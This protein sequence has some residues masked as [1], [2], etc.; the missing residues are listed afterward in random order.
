MRPLAGIILCDEVSRGA[1]DG[2]RGNEQFDLQF[3]VVSFRIVSLRATGRSR[4]GA[5]TCGAREG[6]FCFHGGTLREAT[7]T[8]R[9]GRSSSVLKVGNGKLGGPRIGLHLQVPSSKLGFRPCVC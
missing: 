5:T 9:E 1:C 3:H 2:E 4:R 7:L 8:E 6:K